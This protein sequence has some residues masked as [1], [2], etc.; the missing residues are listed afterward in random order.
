MQYINTMTV[1]PKLDTY[2]NNTEIKKALTEADFL[3]LEVFHKKVKVL[4]Y[5]NLCI[6]RIM[7]IIGSII[8]IALMIPVTL[9]IAIVKFFLR[10]KGPIFYSH[11]RI[12]MNGKHFKMYKYR[13]MCIDADEKLKELLEKDEK[14]KEEWVKTQKIQNDP[15]ITKI[16]NFLRRTSLDEFPQFINVLKGEMSLVG[17]RAVVDGEIERFGLLKNKVL[18]VK[19]GITGRWAANG[20]S[21]ISYDERVA[22]EAAYV[23][24]F[25]I[26]QDIKILFKTIACVLKKEGAI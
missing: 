18:S 4:R 15:R 12:G 10:E 1:S 6:K 20:R 16:G 2:N 19:P 17:P 13:S 9:G 21:D 26:F 5:L 8:G 3:G 25:S 14:I 7:D 11:E 22:M 24:D 23:D